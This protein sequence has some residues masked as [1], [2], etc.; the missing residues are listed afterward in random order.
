MVSLLDYDECDLRLV[1]LLQLLASSSDGD[2]LLGQDSQE[3]AL[4]APVTEH[5]DFLG[6]ATVVLIVELHQELLGHVLHVLDDLLGALQAHVLH[7]HLNLVVHSPRKIVIKGNFKR[8]I[9]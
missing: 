8:R 2:K 9:N 7:P 5:D 1:T 6:L 4:G 3:L